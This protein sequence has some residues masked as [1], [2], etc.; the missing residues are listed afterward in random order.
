MIHRPNTDRLRSAL[1]SHHTNS[2]KVSLLKGLPGKKTGTRR[3]SVERRLTEIEKCR[4]SLDI[5]NRHSAGVE[6]GD[7]EAQLKEQTGAEAEVASV[8]DALKGSSGESGAAM[9]SRIRIVPLR[10]RRF[11][12]ACRYL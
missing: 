11:G 6:L 12:H 4:Y 3:V 5:K 9:T 10:N 2:L 8:S 1:P 7:P